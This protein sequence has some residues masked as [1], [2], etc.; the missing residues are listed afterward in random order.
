MERFSNF[1]L[2]LIYKNN[3]E[4]DRK[5]QIRK[6]I[7]SQA[8]QMYVL[9][10]LKTSGWFP[11][12]WIVNEGKTE[13][14]C[15]SLDVTSGIDYFFR[16]V[17]QKYN[18]AVGSRMRFEKKPFRCFGFKFSEYE[19]VKLA[20]E[21]GGVTKSL[22]VQAFVKFR[23]KAL[24]LKTLDEDEM[25]RQKAYA[26]LESIR[27]VDCI[28]NL[29]VYDVDDMMDAVDRGRCK[30]KDWKTHRENDK[31]WEISFS[32]MLKYYPEKTI[33]WENLACQPNSADQDNFWSEL[34][35]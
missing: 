21:N 13:K 5:A 27:P 35:L 24:F 1:D 12:L 19:M 22:S 2:D 14:A 33:V 23:I 26:E 30:L 11:G 32:D 7:S 10:V 31:T 4:T 28:Y 25:V 8:F 6:Y 16:P 15:F 9:P 3:N 17:G 34:I 20:K 18:I 29:G